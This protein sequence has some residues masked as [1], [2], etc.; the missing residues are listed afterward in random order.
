MNER[1]LRKAIE[2]LKR[3]HNALLAEREYLGQMGHQEDPN[4]DYDSLDKEVTN[5]LMSSVKQRQ[6]RIN[7]KGK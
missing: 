5:L 4:V 1:Q 6:E 2:L 3:T 7:K